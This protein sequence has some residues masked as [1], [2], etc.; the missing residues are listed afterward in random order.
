MLHRLA[1]L[2]GHHSPL[3]APPAP[4]G[5]GGRTPWSAKTDAVLH[6]FLCEVPDLDQPESRHLLLADLRDRLGPSAPFVVPDGPQARDHLLQLVRACRQWH[7]PFH[8]LSELGE[9]LR[10]LRPGTAAV[11]WLDAA[12]DAVVKPGLLDPQAQLV[13]LWTL[14][15]L[16]PQPR[17]A[18]VLHLVESACEPG[19]THPVRPQD[20]LPEAVSRLN[21]ARLDDRPPLLLRF[22]VRLAAACPGPEAVLL[23]DLVKRHAHELGLTER[24][25]AAPARQTREAAGPAQHHPLVLQIT[26]DD[27]SPVGS[28]AEPVYEFEAALYSTDEQPWRLISKRAGDEPLPRSALEQHGSRHLTTWGDLAAAAAN[29]DG[30]RVEFLLPWSLLGH[31]AELWPMDEDG[32]RVGMHFPVVVRSLDRIRSA[33][34]HTAWKNKWRALEATVESSGP[35]TVADLPGWIVHP[36]GTAPI[37]AELTGRA[38]HLGGTKGD[39]R[40]WLDSRPQTAILALSFPYAYHPK[41]RGIGHQAVKDAVREGIPVMIWRRDDTGSPAEI[42]VL[43]AELSATQLPALATHV[44][45]RRRAAREDDGS[46][47]GHHLTLLWDEPGHAAWLAPAPFR[48]PVPVPA[49][50]SAPVSSTAPSPEGPHA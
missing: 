11:G 21:Q 41:R 14:R 47:L 25:L 4:G 19:E 28:D 29:A 10:T 40:R 23:T 49:S 33:F 26:L 42:N 24:D 35:G 39:V 50:V 8:A 7:E 15:S 48:A 45:R 12:V 22:L 13:L 34:W 9:S 16:N 43:L 1:K 5:P 46:D 37:D 44:Q 20:G 32:Y 3:G 30:L 31:P 6:A 2:G 36:D 38:L 18:R 17:P 27:V